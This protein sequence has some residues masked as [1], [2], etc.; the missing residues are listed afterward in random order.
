MFTQD[1]MNDKEVFAPTFR[2]RFGLGH[3]TVKT[4]SRH[5]WPTSGYFTHLCQPIVVMFLHRNQVHNARKALYLPVP[6]VKSNDGHFT[7]SNNPT[8]HSSWYRVI[9]PG[10]F[11]TP[12]RG[13]L[14]NNLRYAVV[15]CFPWIV[16]H[17]GQWS[18]NHTLSL[19]YTRLLA[20]VRSVIPSFL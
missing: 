1:D 4:R 14:R 3:V 16:T 13:L 20:T 8:D 15:G 10:T 11:Q 5:N 6:I 19:D 2:C 17:C 7:C 9:V 12:L 18:D